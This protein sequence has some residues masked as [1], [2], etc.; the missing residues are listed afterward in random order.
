MLGLVWLLAF[1]S[2]YEGAVFPFFVLSL[3]IWV[4]CIVP[5]FYVEVV[6]K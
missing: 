2:C 1:L 6:E 5:A 3:A 4:V